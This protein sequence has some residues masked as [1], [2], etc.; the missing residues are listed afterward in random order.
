M[1]LLK[2][3][4]GINCA[5]YPSIQMK[6][7]ANQ[8]DTA[9]D[10]SIPQAKGEGNLTEGKSSPDRRGAGAGADYNPHEIASQFP[11]GMEITDEQRAENHKKL[12]EMRAQGQNSENRTDGK[13]HDKSND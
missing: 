3:L 8:H 10:I 7:E 2:T 6:K 13:G 11:E 4:H 1:V 12:E 9:K 5:I